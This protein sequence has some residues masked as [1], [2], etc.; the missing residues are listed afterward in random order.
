MGTAKLIVKGSMEDLEKLLFL[1][2]F[3][4]K[5]DSLLPAA[6]TEKI[7]HRIF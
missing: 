7:I 1:M 6:S 2:F 5:I 3:I 4:K